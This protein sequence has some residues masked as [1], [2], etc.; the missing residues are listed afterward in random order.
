MD[1]SLLGCCRAVSLHDREVGND[2]CDS[3]VSKARVAL[4]GD[5]DVSLD[6]SKKW[7][8]GTCLSSMNFIPHRSDV[9]MHDVL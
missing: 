3:K 4:L 2:C 5:Q 9:A 6:K 7:R 1:G 8:I